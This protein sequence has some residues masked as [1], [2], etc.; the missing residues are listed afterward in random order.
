MPDS[1][2]R[3]IVA[4]LH[5]HS[6]A[7][8]GELSPA[9]VVAQAA[10]KG[11]TAVA[12]TDHDTLAGL[13]EAL[14]AGGAAAILVIPGVEL[15]LRFKRPEFVGSLHLLLYFQP[16][17]LRQ[18]TFCRTLEE[19]F[20]AGRGS[21]LARERVAAINRVYGPTGSCPRLKRILTTTE[22]ESLADNVTRR[23]FARV[24]AENHQL[25]RG[26]VNEIIANHSPA[27]IP[28]GVDPEKVPPLRAKFPFL[29]LLAHPAAGSFPPPSHYR[30]VLPPWPVVAGLLPELLDAQKLG[31]DGLEIEYPGH[32][33][34]EKRILRR[35]AAEQGL[36]VG[37]GSDGH[38]LRERPYGVAGLEQADWE[39]FQAR[40]N[41]L[42]RP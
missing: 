29:S 42:A 6:L 14:A 41:T 22:L 16:E 28:S 40:F 3:K 33:E 34:Q 12:L 26:Q 38:D 32:R 7:S 17:W 20:A 39:R 27:Y 8:D 9:E 19:L 36:L 11:L 35:L 15:T 24:L 2:P 37:G 31:L 5:N 13:D 18:P 21:S 1:T 23:H 4:D 25:A 30:E 10:A